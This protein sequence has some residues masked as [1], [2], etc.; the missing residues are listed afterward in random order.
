M[1]DGSYNATA[2]SFIYKYYTYNIKCEYQLIGS[3]GSNVYNFIQTKNFNI[4]SPSFDTDPCIKTTSKK[5]E[6]VTIQDGVLRYILRGQERPNINASLVQHQCLSFASEIVE[7]F[8]NKIESMF[9]NPYSIWN[10]IIHIWEQTT[11]YGKEFVSYY[12]KSFLKESDVQFAL[13][14]F[15]HNRFNELLSDYYLSLIYYK[16]NDIE[17]AV[18][19]AEKSLNKG[20]TV[21]EKLFIDLVMSNNIKNKYSKAIA[22]IL[23][24]QKDYP[25]YYARMGR[26]FKYGKGV[27]KNITE[28]IKNYRIASDHGVSWAKNELFD[29]LLTLNDR[30]YINEMIDLITNRPDDAGAIKRIELLKQRYPDV[31]IP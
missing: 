29:L 8:D 9:F 6:R 4:G 17:S 30:N 11:D 2:L 1:F 22:C 18:H 26:L 28:A 21:A 27:E 19:Y 10:P 16:Q 7:M 20:I 24:L 15:S 3:P 25:E 5:V 23:E 13:D 31:V 12:S 14:V